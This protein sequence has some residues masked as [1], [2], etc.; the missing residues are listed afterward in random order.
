LCAGIILDVTESV[1]VTLLRRTLASSAQFECASCHQQRQTG[2]KTLLQQNPLILN[3]EC[4]QMQV[5]L[6]NKHKMEMVI[7]SGRYAGI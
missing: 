2:S 6:Y 5:N 4:W 3:W 1:Q 7:G